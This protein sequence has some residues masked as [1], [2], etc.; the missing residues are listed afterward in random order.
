MVTSNAVKLA[1]ATCVNC[2]A[3]EKTDILLSQHEPY[4][5]YNQ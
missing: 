2:S 1:P 3:A 4:V 5:L